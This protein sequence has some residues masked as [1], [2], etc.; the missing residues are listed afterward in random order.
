[1]KDDNLNPMDLLV[2]RSRKNLIESLRG[3]MK[4]GEFILSSGL[5]SDFYIDCKEIL[6]KPNIMKAAAIC[7]MNEFVDWYKLD[8]AAS[9]KWDLSFAGPISGACPIVCGLVSNFNVNGLFIRDRAKT[10]GTKKL[11]EGSYIEDSKVVIV[12]DVLTTG[13]SLTNSYISL[14]EN[15]LE[16]IMAIVLVDR[17]EEGDKELCYFQNNWGIP[18]RRITTKEELLNGHTENNR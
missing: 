7:V 2:K 4:T 17:Q 5:K 9:F 13:K 15:G 18:V 12:D 14:S 3:V 6:L 16:P 8:N 10:Y 11:I 1:M